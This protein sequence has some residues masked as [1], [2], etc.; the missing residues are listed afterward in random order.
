MKKWSNT[1]YENNR[2]KI[3]KYQNDYYSKN[4]KKK[5]KKYFKNTLLKLIKDRLGGK[6]ERRNKN[7]KRRF[8]YV[9]R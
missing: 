4:K 1:Y 8:S 7:N 9:V 3:L 2:D 5:T 6:Y